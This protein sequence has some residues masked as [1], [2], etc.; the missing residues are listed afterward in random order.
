MAKDAAKDQDIERA[1]VSYE[2]VLADKDVDAVYTFHCRT[3][4]I[5]SG[6]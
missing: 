1:H 5:W 6:L 3:H 4:C 2:A